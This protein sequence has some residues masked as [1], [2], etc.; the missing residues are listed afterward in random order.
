M[1]VGIRSKNIGLH[2]FSRTRTYEQA[3]GVVLQK[4]VISIAIRFQAHMNP[5]INS[6]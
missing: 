1:D 2:L 5:V 4:A 3:F 6:K